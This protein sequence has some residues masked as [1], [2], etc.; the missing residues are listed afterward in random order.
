MIEEVAEVDVEEL[1][2][3]LLHHQV[4]VV[5]VSDS[6]DVRGHRLASTRRDEVEVVCLQPSFDDVNRA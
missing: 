1:A 3:H 4:T 6:K 2:S 5:S